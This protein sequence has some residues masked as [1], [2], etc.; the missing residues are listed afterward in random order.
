LKT[1]LCI[2][3]HQNSLLALSI[4]L[5]FS[6][7]QPL[8]RNYD[9]DSKEKTAS[10][11]QCRRLNE[12]EP[13]VRLRRETSW[14][15]PETA[16]ISLHNNS[17]CTIILIATGKQIV[18]KPGGKIET[19]SSDTAEDTAQVILRYKVNS[20]K[21][22]ETFITYWPYG[23][24]I[25]SLRLNGGHSIKFTVPSEFLKDNRRIAVPFYYEWEGILNSTGIEHMVYL[26][27]Q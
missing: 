10:A 6:F 2:E 14:R 8:N 5:F 21:Q 23:D 20:N 11:A 22:P 16:R 12:R 1:R 24:T 15:D 13:S 3:H 17:S 7:A 19:I 9:S 4:A 18:T 26:I 27:N 25:S